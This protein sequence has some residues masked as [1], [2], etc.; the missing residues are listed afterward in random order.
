MKRL[1]WLAF[2]TVCYVA[3]GCDIDTVD[4]LKGGDALSKDAF[5]AKYV[6][7]ARCGRQTFAMVLPVTVFEIIDRPLLIRHGCDEWA[8]KDHWDTE[9]MAATRG[10]APVRTATAGE[11]Q[12]VR[13]GRR[14]EP[15]RDF[16]SAAQDGQGRVEVVRDHRFMYSNSDLIGI[17]ALSKPMMFWYARHGMYAR[18]TRTLRF[19]AGLHP[20]IFSWR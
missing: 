11:M 18:R 1:R 9:K 7:K 3:A 14:R 19:D 20:R 2:C 4:G 10:D 13:A 15:L 17:E 6:R 12:E 16:L 5:V 8:G